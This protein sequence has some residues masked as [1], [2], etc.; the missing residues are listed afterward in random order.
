MS[1]QWIMTRM[2]KRYDVSDLY[3]RSNRCADTL[4]RQVHHM[5]LSKFLQP[6]QT[7]FRADSRVLRTADG[8]VGKDGVFADA[9]TAAAVRN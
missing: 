5:S 4:L 1:A 3:G 9:V 6:I 7:E 2:T 8:N